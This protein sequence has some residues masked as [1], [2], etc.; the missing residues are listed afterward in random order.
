MQTEFCNFV[1]SIGY[2]I[3]LDLD[4]TFVYVWVRKRGSLTDMQVQT[5]TLLWHQHCPTLTLWITNPNSPVGYFWRKLTPSQ[6]GPV[7]DGCFLGNRFGERSEGNMI[8]DNTPHFQINT[9]LPWYCEQSSSQC[10]HIKK[11][12]R[13]FLTSFLWTFTMTIFICVKEWGS[14]LNILQEKLIESA[15]WFQISV[16]SFIYDKPPC[17]L[18][19]KSFL[20]VSPLMI[21]LVKPQNFKT[22]I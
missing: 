17:P 20:L 13:G 16:W 6:P 22:L 7:E 15:F 9:E 18:N 19:H 10:G 4:V 14:S 8:F 21:M 3:L 2:Y 5:K 12:T 11:G 1:S